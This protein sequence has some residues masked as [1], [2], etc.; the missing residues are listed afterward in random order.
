[1]RLA[2][3]DPTPER[4]A[5]ARKVLDRGKPWRG[6]HDIWFAPEPLAD[7]GK[8]AFVFPGVEA[9]FAPNLDDVA[10]ALGVAAPAIAA[11]I[12]APTR[13][14]LER[15]GAGVFALGRLLAARARAGSA[16]R[17]TL[18]AGHSLGEWTGMVASEMIP[19]ARDRRV[20]RA[21]L[22]A[23]SLEVPDVVFAAVGCG[24]AGARGR[25]RRARRHRGLARQ[26]PA[27]EHPVRRARSRA[28][29]DRAARRS[30]ACCA[31][32]CRSARAST[33]RCS[34]TTSR[35]TARTS[36]TLALQRAARAAVVG[37][38]VR[39]V[40]RRARRDPRARDRSP[41]RAGA[42]PR[43][44]S[45]ALYASGVRAFVQL[46]VG[47]L[48]GFVD[49][50]LRGKDH[51]AIAAASAT[52]RRRSRSSRASRAALFADGFAV[53]RR[54]AREAAARRRVAQP[55]RARMVSST[56]GVPLVP[57]GGAVPPIS[58]RAPTP[59]S[60]AGGDP[61]LAELRRD[62]ATRPPHASRA[63]VDAYRAKRASRRPRER[64]VTRTLSV[65]AR[66]RAARS[67]LLSPAR[68]A[69][70]PS[71]SLSRSCR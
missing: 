70:R 3:L 43:A 54:A 61:V 5:I 62:A 67:L 1:M 16:S 60:D 49:D 29:R 66:A 14:T 30:A 26:L 39:A 42:V 51:L 6:N 47:S 19:P 52:A 21:A 48:A 15:R 7:G 8:L 37:D 45:S 68:R 11:A 53:E 10:R 40:P 22:P 55:R 58:T 34:P 27:P 35:R 9:T 25:A 36:P 12:G 4:R 69:G 13:A 17:P 59:R 24:A 71:R 50:T 28:R 64:V 23:G 32:S 41:R 46:G 38:D 31:R 44:R 57:L 2:M 56:L 33:R 63:V 65:D 18:I 20:R